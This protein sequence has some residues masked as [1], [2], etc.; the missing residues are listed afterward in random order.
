MNKAEPQPFDESEKSLIGRIKDL[1]DKSTQT[2]IFLSFAF[3]AVVTL[4]SDHA[5]AEGPQRMLKYAL[6]WWVG[7]LPFI[8][9]GIIPVRDYFEHSQNRYYALS[10]I[11]W[12]KV[13]FL[14]LAVAIILIGAGC[15][16]CGIWRD[17]SATGTHKSMPLSSQL[18]S[19]EEE[20]AQQLLRGLSLGDVISVCGKPS[21]DHTGDYGNFKWRILTYQNFEA[22]FILKEGHWQY[23]FMNDRSGRVLP[24]ADMVSRPAAIKLPCQP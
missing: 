15:F 5:I 10:I 20:Y 18:P 4:K 24:D 17:K 8:L 21:L 9:A 23:D 13:C 1:G 14:T 11:R 22:N 3:V 16:G 12:W 19:P 7:A 2:L 6:L